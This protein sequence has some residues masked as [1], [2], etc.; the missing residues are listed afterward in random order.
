MADK[1]LR[2]KKNSSRQERKVSQRKKERKDTDS[3]KLK[4]LLANLG[5]LCLS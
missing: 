2:E 1:S 3:L 5:V 4:N